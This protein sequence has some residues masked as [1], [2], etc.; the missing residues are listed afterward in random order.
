VRRLS[1]KAPDG[2]KAFSRL[3]IR[4]KAMVAATKP[5]REKDGGGSRAGFGGLGEDGSGGG[6][7]DGTGLRSGEAV[8]KTATTTAGKGK[9]GGGCCR[10]TGRRRLRRLATS[11]SGS[12]QQHER[13][14]MG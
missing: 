3:G 5:Q 2:G 8:V 13:M 9:G 10:G 6:G 4:R 14:G 12:G 7:E 1:V 11:F